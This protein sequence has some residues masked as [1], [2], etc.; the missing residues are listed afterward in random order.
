MTLD[1][2][3]VRAALYPRPV[4]FYKRV[5]S[6]ND[7]ALD[8]LRQGAPSG[9]V[10]IADEQVKGRGR[11]G[12]VWY[13]PPG[14]SLIV[15]II[16]RPSLQQ[17]SQLTMLGALAICEL[18]E[19]LGAQVVDIKWPNDVQLHGR[20][21]SGVLPEVIWTGDEIE[22]A[23]LGM[24]INVRIDFGGTELADR[25]ISIEP[26]LERPVNRLELLK[27]LLG[28]VDV[29]MPRLGTDRL[30]DEWRTRLRTIGQIVT[31]DSLEG[32]VHGMAEGV[33]QDGAL[34]VRD[35]D[36]RFH[37]AIAGDIVMGDRSM[38]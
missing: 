16:M 34:L 18:L 12:R 35:R 6:T 8:W 20:K 23:V 32:V 26:A 15:S 1:A 19:S 38:L 2:E 25:A 3:T 13:T 24:G 28:R 21:V 36:G 10:V 11:V 5:D 9:A 14:T 33:D 29:W 22:G 4:R 27:F 31:V 7:M 30:Y 37:R 17:I